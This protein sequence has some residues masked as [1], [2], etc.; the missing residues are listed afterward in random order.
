MRTRHIF[1]VLLCVG[2]S[3]MV[4]CAYKTP[5]EILLRTNAEQEIVLTDGDEIQATTQEGTLIVRAGENDKRS[6]EW[7]GAV[8]TA[9]MI[10]RPAPWYGHLGIYSPGQSGMWWKHDGVTR[11][12]YDEYC[13]SFPTKEEAEKYLL[14]WYAGEVIHYDSD[15]DKKPAGVW[16]DSGLVVWW[17]RSRWAECLSVTIIQVYIDGK[18]PVELKGSQN[19][20]L[21]LNRKGGSS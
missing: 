2:M 17:K 4:S 1:I 11:I 12:D 18:K 16:N 20:N 13:L 7:A 6:F 14:K 21:T 8:R 9:K 19:D 5:P 15:T 3:G 10:R